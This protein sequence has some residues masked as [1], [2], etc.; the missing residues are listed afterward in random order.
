MATAGLWVAER[1]G[2]R[3]EV[4]LPRWAAGL[5][6]ACA[7]LI[8]PYLA[9]ASITAAAAARTAAAYSAAAEPQDHD[10]WISVWEGLGDFDR[11]HGYVWDDTDAQV[12]VGDWRLGSLRSSAILRDQVLRGIRA[13]PLWYAGILL[14][15]TMAT[16]SQWKLLPWGPLGGRSM[17]PRGH[18]NEGAIDSYYALTATLDWF[19]IGPWRVEVPV[20]VFWIAIVAT[21]VL[22]F[23]RP[24]PE[25]RAAGLVLGLVMV[26]TLA[27]PVAITTAGALE[28][29]AI[30]VAYFLAIALLADL[31]LR[32]R[33]IIP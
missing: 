20:P 28:T 11:K 14:K 27:L 1:D 29:Q 31:G 5:A 21:F 2:A 26:A 16:L 30:A 24:S 19:R 13:D 7:V 4:A 9:L 33:R 23:R 22:A 3:R 6:A 8:G 32:A 12:A 18:Y 17:R 25:S 15:R 10:V